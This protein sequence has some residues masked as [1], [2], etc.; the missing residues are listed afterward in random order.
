MHLTEKPAGLILAGGAASRLGGEK[1]M[2]PFDG[3]TLLDAVIARVASQVSTLALSVRTGDGRCYASRYANF[4]LVFDASIDHAGPL[5]GIV[6]GLEWLARRDGARWLAAFPCDTPFLPHDLVSQLWARTRDA[7]VFA[8]DGERLHGVCAIW[9]LE[10][11]DRLRTGVETGKL[12]SLQGALSELGGETC[13]IAAPPHAFFNINT[14]D[15][16][17]EAERL[18]SNS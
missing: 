11:L 9:P 8:R 6:A 1:A 5:A 7:P 16:L 3:A 15:D 10:C 4:P 14:Q 17:Q 2:L 12:R 18:A 13:L